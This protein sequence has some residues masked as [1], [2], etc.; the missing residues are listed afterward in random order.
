MRTVDAIAADYAG[1]LRVVKVNTDVSRQAA[2][3]YR[4]EGIPTL[5]LFKAGQPVERVVGVL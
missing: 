4:I 3:N 2:M 5:L 1:K